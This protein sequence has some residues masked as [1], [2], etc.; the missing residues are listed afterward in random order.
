MTEPPHRRV[1]GWW[2]RFW[3]APIDPLPLALFRQAFAWTAL[4]YF[5][6]WARFA[7]EWLTNV[8]YHPPA[9]LDAVNSPQLPLLPEWALPVVGAIFFGALLAYIFGF[10]RRVVVWIVFAGAVYALQVD[11]IAAFTLNRLFVLGFF[12]LAISPEPQAASASPETDAPPASPETDAPPTQRAWPTRMLQVT[13]VSMYCASGLCKSI[14]GD[15]WTGEDVL[16][17]QVQGLYMTDTA[18][19]MVRTLPHWMWTVQEK[20]ALWFEILAPLLF[21]V[22]RLLPIAFVIGLGLHIVVAVTMD[23]L[24]YFSLQMM[25]FYLLFIPGECYRRYLPEVLLDRAGA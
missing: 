14:N 20:L 3:H 4:I 1:L 17:M 13:V 16:W 18:A 19:W 11:P 12:I 22:R 8:G 23:Q 15:W 7:P 2:E 6:S 5:A 21:G 24:I 25:C 10:A 9:E